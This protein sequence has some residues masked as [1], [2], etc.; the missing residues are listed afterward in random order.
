MSSNRLG[1]GLEA[2]IRPEKESKKKK[3]PKKSS[4]NPGV[5]EILIRDIR[6]NPNQPR[7][8]FDETTLEEL[9]SSIKL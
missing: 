9:A 7:R 3:K 4:A 8:E 2:L 5:T 6:P 1:K